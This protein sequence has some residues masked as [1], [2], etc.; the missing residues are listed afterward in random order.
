MNIFDPS[1]YDYEV[2]MHVVSSHHRYYYIRRVR[3][4]VTDPECEVVLCRASFW[5]LVTGGLHADQEY[6]YKNEADYVF[7]PAD[8][9]KDPYVLMVWKD[10]STPQDLLRAASP[11][12]KEVIFSTR[13][14]V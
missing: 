4:G 10:P 14:G 6:G 5:K 11:S 8:K 7:Y 3:K 12:S 9:I 13:D 2:V 1:T